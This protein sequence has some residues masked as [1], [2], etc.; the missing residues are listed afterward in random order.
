MKETKFK[1]RGKPVTI[2]QFRE[3]RKEPYVNEPPL[4]VRDEAL[5]VRTLLAGISYAALAPQ[6][7]PEPAP[8]LIDREEAA[9]LLGI[10]VDAFDKRVQRRQVPGVVRSAGRRIQVDREKMLAGIAKRV[11]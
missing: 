3:P 7:Q 11:R 6:P 8:V 2:T 9:K 1:V 10:T 4:E 5:L